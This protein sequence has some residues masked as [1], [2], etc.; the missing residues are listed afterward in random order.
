MAPS[1][2]ASEELEKALRDWPITDFRIE[3]HKLGYVQLT[4]NRMLIDPIVVTEA[5]KAFAADHPQAIFT[6]LANTISG[7]SVIPLLNDHRH[8]LHRRTAARAFFFA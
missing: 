7:G 2:A 1:I 8:R 4:S 3:T 5:Q 6:Y